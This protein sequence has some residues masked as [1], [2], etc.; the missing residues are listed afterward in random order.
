MKGGDSALAEEEKKKMLKKIKTII[1]ILLALLILS[2][3]ALAARVVYLNFF[4][5]KSTTTVVPDNI[6]GEESAAATTVTDSSETT[7]P[8][9][10]TGG[11]SKPTESTPSA[12]DTSTPTTNSGSANS[13]KKEATVIELYKEQPSDNEK[14]QVTNMLPG[15]TEV[16][17]FAVKVSHHADAIVY[18]NA[19][20]TEQTKKLANVLHIK[21]T[22]LENEKV[23]YD[24]TFADMNIDGYGETFATTQKTDTVAYYKIEVSLPTSTGNEYQAAKLLA[25]FNW[26]VKDA[27]PLDPPQ[28]GDN[29]NIMLYFIIMCCSLG[30]IIILLFFRRREKEDEYAE[31]K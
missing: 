10:S 13:D 21:V 19:K 11:D 16:K 26:Y 27:G 25:D 28:T 7:V 14:F 5:D 31:A 15:D 4:D 18:F 24:G 8:S 29:S 22:C 6:I 23:I 9:E 12:S 1:A 30:M 17:Y 3:G 2:A 20:V